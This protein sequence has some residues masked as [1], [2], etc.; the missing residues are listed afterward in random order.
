MSINAT[1]TGSFLTLLSSLRPCRLTSACRSG[2]TSLSLLSFILLTLIP[3]AATAAPPDV[4]TAIPIREAPTI[5]GI[6]NEPFWDGIT[7]ITDFKQREPR[8]GAEPSERTEVRIAYDDDFIYFGLKMFDSEPDRI[9]RTILQREGRIDQDDRVIIGLDTYFDRRNA[10]IFEL[11]PFGTQGDA[12]VTDE[13]Q[14]NWNWEG[15][16][17]SE[18]RITDFGWVLEVAI[19]FTTLRYGEAAEPRMGVAFYRSI[20]RKEEEVF[21]PL[22][23]VDFRRHIFQ[24]SQYAELQGLRDLK[25]QHHIEVKPYGLLGATRPGSAG[26]DT[27]VLKDV[28]VDVKWGLTPN[29]TLD[30]TANTDFARSRPTPSRST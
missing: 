2:G 15:F 14:V 1:A 9:R 25:R 29:F 17:S 12:L 8:E 27:D 23:G 16:Y 21:W 13:S 11:N 28:G 5:D 22:I 7:P 3:V 30:L 6:L 20:R 24:V 4:A 18:G 19:P 26:P 10:Y